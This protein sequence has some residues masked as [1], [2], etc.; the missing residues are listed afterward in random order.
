MS[1]RALVIED[2]PVDR[3]LEES[4]LIGEGYEVEGVVDIKAALERLVTQKYDV[5][6]LDVGLPD[7]DGYDVALRLRTIEPNRDTPLVVITGSTDPAARR[8]G[9]KAGA[10]AFVPKPFTAAQ[11]RA[12]VATVVP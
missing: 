11:F 6:V 2:D 5:I 12:V 3:R 10:V 1:R 8:K 4:L 7:G 9:F